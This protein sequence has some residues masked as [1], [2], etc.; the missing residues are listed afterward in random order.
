MWAGASR[1]WLWLLF[2]GSIF[3][4]SPAF[5]EPYITPRFYFTIIGALLT[6]LL[7]YL[8]PFPKG[9]YK[10]VFNLTLLKGFYGLGALQALYGLMQYVHLVDSH[11]S[12]RMVG[13]FD[14]PAGFA[15]GL[16]LLFPIGLLWRIR[17]R[18]W[19]RTGT[20]MAS[21]LYVAAIVLSESRT[22]ILAILL[23]SLTLV[24]CTFP[25]LRRYL[26]S[27]IVLGGLF[28]VFLVAGVGLYRFKPDSA[29]GRILIWKVSIGMI[30]E[31]PLLGFGPGGF[32]RF[33][34]DHQAQYFKMNPDSGMRM[35]ADNIRHPFNEWLKVGIEYGLPGMIFLCAVI[36][37][38]FRFTGRYSGACREII[39]PALVAA[40][41]WASFSYSLK[42]P[43]NLL[44]VTLY[45]LC[46]LSNLH[47]KNQL[48][49][50][51][52]R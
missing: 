11:S 20:G 8:L 10:K 4:V 38:V 2:G 37:F 29:K 46:G 5:L 28:T 24:F 15:S 7:G 26:K 1:L 31:K 48:L 19:K 22:G 47:V 36:F 50:Y 27:P 17:A 51:L 30:Q 14:N 32:D 18:G 21:L 52:S 13:S 44:L 25:K 16:S 43:P 49:F 42:Y 35:L 45:A 3:V 34:M 9:T 41:I 6:V 23:A 40:L 39:L 33:Y 12:F